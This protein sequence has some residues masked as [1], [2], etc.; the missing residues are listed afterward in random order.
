MGGGYPGGVGGGRG[1]Y[2]G[3]G[4]RDEERQ[5]MQELMRPSNLLALSMTGAEV[6]VVDDQDRKR[7]LMTDG[8][9][10]GKS[11]DAS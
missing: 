7:A 3:R 4:E 9:K 8:R 5:K 11:K 1:G 6:V 10:L 2:G